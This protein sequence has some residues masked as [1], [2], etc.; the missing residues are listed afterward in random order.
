MSEPHAYRALVPNVCRPT[1]RPRSLHI[2][3][4]SEALI[5]D[6]HQQR[7]TDVDDL[8]DEGIF[9]IV[10]GV[11]FDLGEDEG[12]AVVNYTLGEAGDWE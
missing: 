10:R 2:C 8:R 9:L 3:D 7:D 5:P 4:S 6:V 11:G 12:V 1:A